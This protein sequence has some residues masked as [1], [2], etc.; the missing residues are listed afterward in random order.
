MLAPPLLMI[1]AGA[2]GFVLFISTGAVGTPYLVTFAVAAVAGTFLVAPHGLVVTV[3]QI[4]ILYTFITIAVGW[5]GSSWVSSGGGGD[6]GRRTKL[7]TAAYPII[8]HFP[9]LAGL[10]LICILLAGWRL[11]DEGRKFAKNSQAR[12][13]RSRRARQR[14]AERVHSVS[15]VQQRLAESDRRTGR[16]RSTAG[17]AT[18]QA[19]E[20]STGAQQPVA[21]AQSRPQQ[22]SQQ[23]A[24]RR[25]Q[26][27][28][29]I[30]QGDSSRP[31][32]PIAEARASQPAAGRRSTPGPH[33][34]PRPGSQRASTPRTSRDGTRSGQRQQGS[35]V[36][37]G[38][39]RP[40]PRA[41]ANVGQA[42]SRPQRQQRAA[43]PLD[44]QQP[45][46]QRPPR[47]AADAPAPQRAAARP[48]QQRTAG[49][50]QASTPRMWGEPATTRGAEEWPPRRERPRRTGRR[51]SE[52]ASQRDSR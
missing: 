44:R 20:R 10:M 25:L 27:T 15:T 45:R 37:S 46:R 8:Q 47:P 31:H 24:R 29:G 21:A 33:R 36:P 22:G 51:L 9:W 40:A 35:R 30:P 26:P 42:S 5:F 38:G 32:R 23:G 19:P 2:V 6:M 3:A 41:T 43:Q 13:S 17:G 49:A 14:D 7:I 18:P 16:R 28:Q 1:A 12:V 52:R 48:P 4:P 34:E 50:N 39:A 11:M